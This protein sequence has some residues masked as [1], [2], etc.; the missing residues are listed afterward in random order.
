MIFR[1]NCSLLFVVLGFSLQPFLAA[2]DIMKGNEGAP[3]GTTFSFPTGAHAANSAGTEFF[4]GATTAGQAGTYALAKLVDGSD[5]FVALAPETVS[6]NGK[7]EQ[8][9]PLFNAGIRFL[10]ALERNGSVRLA[11]TKTGAGE[12]ANV[13]AIDHVFNESS[14][15]VLQALNVKDA[16]GS[17]VAADIVGLGGALDSVI[18]AAVVGNGGTDFGDAGSGVAV[19]DITDEARKNNKTRR[20]LRQRDVGTGTPANAGDT[21]AAALDRTSASIKI[22]SDVAS[23]ANAVAFHW[24]IT[25][26]VLYVALQVESAAG[27]DTDGARSI[28]VG[29]VDDTGALLFHPFAPDGVFTSGADNEIIGGLSSGGTAASIA[30]YAIKTMRT[31]TFLRYLIVQGGNVTAPDTTHRTVFALPLV[32]K[33][34]GNFARLAPGDLPVQGTLAKKDQ[35]PVPVLSEQAVPR[36]VGRKFDI[37]ATTSADIPI[38]TDRA[39]LVGAGP[40]EAGDIIDMVV[41]G[42]TVFVSVGDPDTNQVAGIFY[43]QALF[44]SLGRINGWTQW[45]RVGGTILNVFGFALDVHVGNFI[46]MTGG[47]S[48]TINTVQRTSWTSNDVQLRGQLPGLIGAVLP[49]N[50]GGIR[51]LQE[52]FPGTPGINDISLMI[53]TGLQGVTLIETGEVTNG[54]LIP[55]QG[56]FASDSVAF[57]NGTITQN[58]PGTLLSLFVS[59]TGGELNE[60]GPISAAEVSAQGTNGWLF[61]GGVGGLAVLAQPNGDGWTTPAQLS[62]NFLGLTAGMAFKKI[63]NYS[64]VRK[65][66]YDRNFLYVLTDTRFDRIDLA[67]S[68]FATNE[69]SVTTLAT[70]PQLTS[71]GTNQGGFLDMLVSEKLAL[72]ATSVGLFRIGNGKDIATVSDLTDAA[73]IP[74]GLPYAQPPVREIRTI[75]VTGRAQ[76]VTRMGGGTIWFISSYYGKDR[77]QI[78]RFSVS[79]T[80]MSAITNTTLVTLP[81]LLLDTPYDN[82]APAF[83]VNFGQVRSVVI[84][85]GIIF[86]NARNRELERPPFV[87]NGIHKA[88]IVIPL[89]DIEN[90]GDVTSILRSIA[91]GS[92]FITGNFGLRLNE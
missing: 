46:F 76:D 45:A 52:F 42:D 8:H 4:V 51:L 75:S 84:D 77:G 2:A 21:R 55:T 43:S 44:D 10:S 72:L 13:Y 86:L 90:A 14:I 30:A 29:T 7:Q 89:K 28:V 48:A 26:G 61:V 18:V 70:I 32:D 6:I 62:K 41:S 68:N 65:L 83:Y 37:P 25:L 35:D 3:S 60:L 39:A 36:F 11:I 27:A 9:N 22:G 31:S 91:S 67:N 66:L 40:L 63:G 20:I 79:D 74:V 12:Q 33:R 24:D 19:L 82:G 16:S 80:T 5:F 49:E 54:V 34:V 73:W 87:H 64:F 56:D 92:W 58:F 50:R 69:L 78:N 59:I 71:S 47:S 38:S 88:R 81:D 53:A 85:D 23:L 1:R 15:A 57:E 17:A